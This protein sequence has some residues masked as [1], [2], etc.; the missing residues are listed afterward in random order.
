MKPELTEVKSQTFETQDQG[1]GPVQVLEVEY[2]TGE[3]RDVELF[4]QPGLASGATQSHKV[5]VM[6]I[7]GGGYKVGIAAHNYE[8]GLEVS[9]G[10]T[11][12]YSTDSAGSTRKALIHLKADGKIDI[13]NDT[14]GLKSVLSDLIDEIKNLQTFGSPANHT[15]DTASQTA[16][17]AIKTR[18]GTLLS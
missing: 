8:L 3:L 10:E 18:L 15:V 2:P 17:T 16:L 4:Q 5:I 1:A 12:L 9:A 6:P 11:K 7:S 13:K 14:E